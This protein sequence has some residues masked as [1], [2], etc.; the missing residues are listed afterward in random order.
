MPQSRN[1]VNLT[2]S[3][4]RLEYSESALIFS[5]E[6][7]YSSPFHVR[8]GK[9]GLLHP[10]HLWSG[11]V[12]Q[13]QFIGNLCCGCRWSRFQL[14]VIFHLQSTLLSTQGYLILSRQ[15]ATSLLVCCCQRFSV[16]IVNS[17]Y[18]GNYFSS[19]VWILL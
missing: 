10:V 4:T 19:I 9:S 5:H 16:P 12:S 14:I 6:R 15:C 3:H 8:E 1:G 2:S 13:V 18:Y 7:Y 11:G 17:I